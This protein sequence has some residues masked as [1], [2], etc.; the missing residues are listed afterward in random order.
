[1]T[2]KVFIGIPVHS[3]NV[4]VS[5]VISLLTT[6][7]E[8]GAKG[9]PN[10]TVYFRVGDSDLCRARNA[11]VGRFLK[12]DCTDL[13]MIDSDI[14]WNEGTIARL[15]EHDVDFVAAPYKGR[16]DEKE[17]YF[18]RWPKN[19]EMWTDPKTGFPLLKVDAVTIG[20]CRL[21][22]S[23][24]EKMVD[25]LNGHTVIDP[26]WDDEEFPWLIDFV[27]RDGQRFE[28]GYA[29]CFRWRDMGGDVWVDPAINLGHMGPKVFEGNLIEFLRKMQTVTFMHGEDKVNEA[30]NEGLDPKLLQAG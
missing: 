24:V 22:R 6:V 27:H 15:L 16:T 26:L 13:M 29:L 20:F 9:W 19:K 28:E 5:T 3:G 12:S 23:C 14:S 11:I 2:P 30:I 8:F 18:I 1:M 10:P 21:R 7:M 17:M 4:M 25:T